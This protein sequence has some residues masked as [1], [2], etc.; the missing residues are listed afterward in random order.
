MWSKIT[1]K[2]QKITKLFFLIC[3]KNLFI[4]F[5]FSLFID[6]FLVLVQARWKSAYKKEFPYHQP[7]DL[8]YSDP[9]GLRQTGEVL[10]QYE[11]LP[12]AVSETRIRHAAIP[13]EKPE[14]D[15]SWSEGRTFN[16]EFLGGDPRLTSFED[17]SS[18][19]DH[20]AHSVTDRVQ[21]DKITRIEQSCHVPIGDPKLN[22]RFLRAKNIEEYPKHGL[23]EKREPS[24]H[25]SQPCKFFPFFSSFFQVFS[26]F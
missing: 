11:N 20:C 2:K 14:R 8:E 9:L 16:R 24:Y 18:K 22:N 13:Y 4:N 5:C 15:F 17:T 3:K 21:L 6:I 19:A 1:F 12:F 10:L 23:V 26:N 25:G 7:S